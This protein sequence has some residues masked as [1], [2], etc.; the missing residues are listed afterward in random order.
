MKR[1]LKQKYSVFNRKENKWVILT[2]TA[3]ECAKAMGIR[4]DTFYH[5]KMYKYRNKYGTK[6]GIVKHRKDF[7]V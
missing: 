6:W 5:V 3:D 1:E 4:L 7:E 2:S